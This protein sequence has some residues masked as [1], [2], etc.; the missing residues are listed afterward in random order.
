MNGLHYYSKP[1]CHLMTVQARSLALVRKAS[2]RPL[3]RL[4]SC[5]SGGRHGGCSPLTLACATTTSRDVVVDGLY[6]NY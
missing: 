2:G 3:K 1:I 5:V 4:Q 6:Q